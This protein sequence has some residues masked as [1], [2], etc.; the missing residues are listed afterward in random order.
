MTEDL[1]ETTYNIIIGL[2]KHNI[3]KGGSPSEVI[4]VIMNVLHSICEHASG[5][6]IAAF[7][8]MILEMLDSLD[9]ASYKSA[10]NSDLH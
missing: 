10:A 4:F 2:F 7:R 6:D 3:Q 8:E 1:T 5:G 9:A